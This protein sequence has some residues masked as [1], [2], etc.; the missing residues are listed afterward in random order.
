[1]RAN[2]A[3]VVVEDAEGEEAAAAVVVVVAGTTTKDTVHLEAETKSPGRMTLAHCFF[4]TI[5]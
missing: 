1:V 4:L 3:A 2:L 5:Y